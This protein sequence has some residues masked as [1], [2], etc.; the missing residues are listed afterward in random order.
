MCD[1]YPHR[2]PGDL[3]IFMAPVELVGLARPE[4]QRDKGGDAIAS[5]L[6][7]LD[8]P[9][10][11]IAPHRIVRT[12]KAFAHQQVMDPRHPQPMARRSG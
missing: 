12:L 2:C 5:V 1:L 10:R 6:A 11:R 3:N 8:L 9:A 4:H 7:P